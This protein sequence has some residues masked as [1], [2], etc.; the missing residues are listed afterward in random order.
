M[1]KLLLCF[2][3][4]LRSQAKVVIT[5]RYIRGVMVILALLL[6]SAANLVEFS[7][8]ADHD[9]TTPPVV[10]DLHFVVGNQHRLPRI[11]LFNQGLKPAHSFA[12]YP[13]R[14]FVADV[15]HLSPIE[16]S[17]QHLLPLLC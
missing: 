17:P 9:E 11:A 5:T 13:D 16:P 6:A 15:N 8:D 14:N 10:V 7:Y 2:Q 4:L 3:Q 12:S 1:K